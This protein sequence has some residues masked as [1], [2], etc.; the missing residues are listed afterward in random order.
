LSQ[1]ATSPTAGN[2]YLSFFFSF[3]FKRASLWCAEIVRVA[4]EKEEVVANESRRRLNTAKHGR[5]NGRSGPG[6][7][8]LCHLRRLF[9]HDYWH[10][11][12]L[13]HITL[14][15]ALPLSL[16]FNAQFSSISSIPPFILRTAQL[17]MTEQR[18]R[19]FS[20]MNCLGIFYSPHLAHA[21]S[22][23]DAVCRAALL[24]GG[25]IFLGFGF[26]HILPEAA[27]VDAHSLVE[28]E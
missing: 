27:Y 18:Q 1:L 10:V 7:Q 3:S 28:A 9:L 24:S 15:K 8:N 17:E 23:P 6:R 22:S 2:I 13:A 21:H 19:L 16:V 26:L 14:H 5:I 20:W 12:A 4:Q 25:G 11:R